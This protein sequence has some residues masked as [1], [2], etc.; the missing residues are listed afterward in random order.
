MLKSLNPVPGGCEHRSGSGARHPV[1]RAAAVHRLWSV[2]S[3]S[4]HC[5][6][7]TSSYQEIRCPSLANE[8]ERQ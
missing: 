3:S 2:Q 4:F 1:E 5:G 6:E 7:A 8:G